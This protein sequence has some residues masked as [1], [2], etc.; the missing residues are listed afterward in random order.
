MRNEIE[1][2]KINQ[3]ECDRMSKNRYVIFSNFLRVSF[4]LCNAHESEIELIVIKY[5]AEIENCNLNKRKE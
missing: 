3:F 2:N 5:R 1:I 4:Q